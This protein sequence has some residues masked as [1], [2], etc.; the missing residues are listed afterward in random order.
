MTD[1]HKVARLVDLKLFNFVC[2]YYEHWLIH[3]I[4]LKS[5]CELVAVLLSVISL[6]IVL[7]FYCGN[8]STVISCFLCSCVTGNLSTVISCFLCSCVTGNL[9]QVGDRVVVEASYNPSMPFKWNAMRVQSLSAGQVSLYSSYYLAPVRL[10]LA[11]LPWC[12]S[13]WFLVTLQTR[14]RYDDVL[15]V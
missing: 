15:C 10:Q 2:F 6:C 8:E 4:M 9:P 1:V 11:P 14:E 3:L 7:L 5:F 13:T 12:W